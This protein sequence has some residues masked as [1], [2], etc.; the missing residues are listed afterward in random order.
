MKGTLEDK[1]FDQA[2]EV[3]RQFSEL[4]NRFLDEIRSMTESSYWLK[5]E[6]E[7]WVS[8]MKKHSDSLQ[9]KIEIL[10]GQM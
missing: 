10:E 6:H 2:D 5:E 8:D 9:C 4:Q 7:Q 3:K 1:R